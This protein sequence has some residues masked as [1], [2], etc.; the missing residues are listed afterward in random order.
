VARPLLTYGFSEDAAYR[1]S[2]LSTE[3]HQ[4]HF[5][6]S[7]PDDLPAI[8]ISLNIPGR[9][10]ALNAA[11]AI[12]VASDEGIG[13]QSIID[14]LGKFSGVGRRFEVIG[15]YPVQGGSAM[16]V[17][18]YGHH[19]TE[20]KATIQAV[21]DGWP[22]RRLVMAFQPHR[23][24]RTRDLYEDF[25]Q[26]LATVDVLLVLDV[27]AAGEE[28]IL[29]AGSKNI[30]GSIRQRGGVDPIYLESIDEVPYLLGELVRGDDIVLT[31]GAG[32]VS[33]LV[34]M[35]TETE[36]GRVLGPDNKSEVKNDYL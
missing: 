21:R 26:V 15:E 31:Q 12:A 32:S 30:C 19:P 4:C 23:Y 5:R 34:A 6:V 33:K 11:A 24:T 10:N 22:G 1:I 20:V 25:I 7:R 14:G 8:N 29:G 35:L 17:D 9:H 16:L 2:D 36:L 13:D 28:P 3:G 27:Y 18:D